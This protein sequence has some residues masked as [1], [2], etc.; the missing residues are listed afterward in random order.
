MYSLLTLLRLYVFIVYFHQSVH[1]SNDKSINLFILS[2]SIYP[3]IYLVLLATNHSFDHVLINLFIHPYIFMYSC[4]YVLIH[5]SIYLFIYSFIYSL[6]NNNNYF[7]SIQMYSSLTIVFSSISP[8]IYSPSLCI[9]LFIHLFTYL[10]IHPYIYVFIMYAL[11]YLFIY[12]FIYSLSN[13]NYF[14]S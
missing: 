2:L 3:S 8:F 7:S 13:N 5:L 11:I 12:L 9:H 1:L 14:S 6:S 4:M 10:L